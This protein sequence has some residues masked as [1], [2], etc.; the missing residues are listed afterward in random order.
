MN[1]AF[2]RPT[3]L[4]LALAGAAS[5]TWTAQGPTLGIA[6][7]P[8]PASGAL[9]LA[10]LTGTWALARRRRFQTPA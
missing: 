10:D 9:W 8:E 5:A 7:V 6:A 4:A 1:A 2:A 3:L